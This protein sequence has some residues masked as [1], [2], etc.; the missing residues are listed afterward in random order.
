MTRAPTS[1]LLRQCRCHSPSESVLE[2]SDRR[3]WM[4]RRRASGSAWAAAVARA[5][6]SRNSANGTCAGALEQ[7]V[8][9]VGV[10]GGG[11]GDR[12]R[13]PGE[14][15]PRRAAAEVAGR[16]S[17]R[18][19]VSMAWAAWLTVVRVRRARRWAAERS[20]SARHDPVSATRA[21]ASALRVAAAFS[22]RDACSH[23]VLGL[24]GR[25]HGR[26]EVGRELAQRLAQLRD[27]HAHGRVLSSTDRP[28]GKC[29]LRT[30]VRILHH[31]APPVQALDASRRSNPETSNGGRDPPHI[32][33]TQLL[34]PTPSV[35]WHSPLLAR[36][37]GPPETAGHAGVIVRRGGA[38]DWDD[39]PGLD[40][41][42]GEEQCP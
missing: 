28:R 17:S 37:P 21:A 30:G 22:I 31:G 41:K 6:C 4:R 27:S 9:G 12:R 26:V 39:E 13:L 40:V 42:K 2:R 38:F 32:S 23:H 16:T 3:W 5:H 34:T 18:R 10:G 15:S 25:E 24:G 8:L 11:V 19:A 29:Q 7:A 14:R 33:S 20:P 36:C 1:G 35:R